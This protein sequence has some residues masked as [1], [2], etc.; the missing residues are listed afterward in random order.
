MMRGMMEV[1]AG[2]KF[3]SQLLAPIAELFL[4][5]GFSSCAV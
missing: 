5:C 2:K 1:A 4:V 3:L